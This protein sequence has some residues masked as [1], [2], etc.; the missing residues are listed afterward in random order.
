MENKSKFAEIEIQF[1]EL[2]CDKDKISVDIGT[3]ISGP[4]TQEM[5]RYSKGVYSYEPHPVSAQQIRDKFGNSIVFREVAVS[6]KVGVA[7]L[8]TPV[9]EG[10]LPGDFTGKS[11]LSSIYKDFNKKGIESARYEVKT[12]TIDAENFP[13]VSL[14]KIDVEGA[15]TEVLNGGMKTLRTHRPYVIIEM[16][17][18]H[19]VGTL[20]LNTS[21]FEK[22]DYSGFY[23]ENKSPHPIREF[24]D[25]GRVN[26]DMSVDSGNIYN[27]FFIPHE[28]MSVMKGIE[29]KLRDM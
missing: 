4:Y 13:P 2:F 26:T 14:I 27:F 7:V 29:T 19:R 23:I 20:R 6:D 9:K 16:D 22:L 15:E 10:L 21:F 17:E 11:D 3:G 24:I 28:K 5:L 18:Q 12:T 1:V 8:S 25:S